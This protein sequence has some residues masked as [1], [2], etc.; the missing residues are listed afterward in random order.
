MA[1][2]QR[3]PVFSVA[4]FFYLLFET[5]VT[6]V[7][8]WCYGGGLG[9]G[10]Q[11]LVVAAGFIKFLLFVHIR[12]WFS[13]RTT[14]SSSPYFIPLIAFEFFPL[15][16]AIDRPHDESAAHAAFQAQKTLFSDFY[17]LMLCCVALSVIFMLI[18]AISLHAGRMGRYPKDSDEGMQGGEH[19]D[20]SLS[21]LYRYFSILDWNRKIITGFFTPLGKVNALS[22]SDEALKRIFAD[23]LLLSVGLPGGDEA[24]ARQALEAGAAMSLEEALACV[25]RPEDHG[26]GEYLTEAFFVVTVTALFYDE[27]LDRKEIGIF[28]QTARAYRIA[29]IRA[30]EILHDLVARY[31]LRYDRDSDSYRADF[32]RGSAQGTGEKTAGAVSD[33]ELRDAYI[34]LQVS[35][36]ISDTELRRAYLRLAAIYHPDRAEARGAGAAELEE[37]NRAAARINSAWEVVSRARGL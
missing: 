17:G 37:S 24:L 36:E 33:R 28:Y 14:I 1:E 15:F 12:R 16:G 31:R 23:D 34:T 10:Q 13:A 11:F 35:P 21:H 8:L 18:V 6:V 25:C 4:D 9:V 29:E 5:C 19:N 22:G 30:H 2:T 32:P 3:P 26:G 7:F 20:F 27:E